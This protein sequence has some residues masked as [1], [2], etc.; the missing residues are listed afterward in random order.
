V[1]RPYE[2]RVT[3]WQRL[4]SELGL[5]LLDEMTR[6]IALSEAIDMAHDLLNGKV[7]GR[8]VVDVNRY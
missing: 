5:A 3:A 1:T 2:E 7:R 8:V 6:E 4:S